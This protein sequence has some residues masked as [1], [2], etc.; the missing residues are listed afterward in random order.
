[1]NNYSRDDLDAKALRRLL[2]A[3]QLAALSDLVGQGSALLFDSVAGEGCWHTEL[4]EE[5]RRLICQR[6]MVRM[7]AEL[8]KPVASSDSRPSTLH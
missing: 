2:N 7:V 3:E 4:S 1:M 5:E 8:F 6:I